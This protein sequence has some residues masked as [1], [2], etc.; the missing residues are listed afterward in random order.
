MVLKMNPIFSAALTAFLLT[1]SFYSSLAQEIYFGQKPPG[2][3]PEIFAPGLVSIEGRYEYGISFTPELNE[4]YFTADIKDEGTSIYYSRI[5]NGKWSTPMRANFTEDRMSSEMEPHVTPD[6]KRIY[7]TAFNSGGYRIWFVAR[8]DDSWSRAEMLDSPLNNENVLYPN[9]E[10][11]G[12]I[13]YTNLSKLKMFCSKYRDGQYPEV[14]EVGNE[15][16]LHGFVDPLKKFMLL[17]APEENNSSRDRDIYV[18]FWNND[19]TWTR[20]IN[21]GK[22]VNTIY[23]ESCASVSPDGKYLFFSRYNET[24]G[25]PN[26]YWVSSEVIRNSEPE[27]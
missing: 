15:Y 6:G 4:V 2:L 22:E 7:F 12:D 14:F 11:N 25:L 23:N 8:M 17:D 19:S 3:V 20:P 21:L 1:F 9:T 26:I 13:Y 5:T 24:S 16:G 10:V 18:C 27:N